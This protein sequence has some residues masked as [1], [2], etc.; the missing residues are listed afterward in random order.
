MTP[1][2][3]NLDE[4]HQFLKD[5]DRE[6]YLNLTRDIAWFIGRYK[7]TKRYGYLEIANSL[8]RKKKELE[9]KHIPPVENSPSTAKEVL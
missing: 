9:N 2:F 3:K 4:Y 1:P 7:A 6:F 8:N 5:G